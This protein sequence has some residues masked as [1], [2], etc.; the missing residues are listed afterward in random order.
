MA[1]PVALPV[2]R[3]WQ[4]FEDFCRDLFAAEWSDPQ[5]KKYGR[6]G[7][8]QEG[9]DVFGRPGTSQR[10]AETVT[11]QLTAVMQGVTSP[12]TSPN[13]REMFLHVAA[14]WVGSCKPS[15]VIAG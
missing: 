2:P 15:V 3:D 4:V 12:S 13:R 11:R 10:P 9:V 8:E 6:P 14:A 1:H 7:Q 5:T